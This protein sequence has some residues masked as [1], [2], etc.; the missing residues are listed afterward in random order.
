MKVQPNT[1]L[2]AFFDNSHPHQ[3]SK[4][5]DV[6]IEMV[7]ENGV[8]SVPIPLPMIGYRPLSVS[9]VI[10]EDRLPPSARLVSARYEAASRICHLTTGVISC[11][12]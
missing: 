5:Q 4:E 11:R 10:L 1:N 8:A 12:K 6:V 7:I 2:S 3:P 9:G